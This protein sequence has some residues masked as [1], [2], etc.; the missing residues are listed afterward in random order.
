MKL[1]MT[2]T[3]AP[4][5]ELD[6]ELHGTIKYNRLVHTS[7]GRGMSFE[8]FVEEMAPVMAGN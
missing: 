7:I 3:L 2:T 6:G 5:A 8:C 4:C 1:K